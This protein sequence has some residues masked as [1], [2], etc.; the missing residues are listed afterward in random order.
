MKSILISLALLFSNLSYGQIITDTSQ[1]WSTSHNAIMSLTL[2]GM[3][4]SQVLVLFDNGN[5][6]NL[7]DKLNLELKNYLSVS[8]PVVLKSILL[9]QK[10][11][12]EMGYKLV[13]SSGFHTNP[14]YYIIHYNFVKK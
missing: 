3:G 14:S 1:S 13:A 4:R 12:D 10:Y 6:I 11:M 9:C 2:S 5:Q 8:S 7:K